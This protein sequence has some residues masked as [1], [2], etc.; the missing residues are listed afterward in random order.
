[1]YYKYIFPLEDVIVLRR[2]CHDSSNVSL[3]LIIAAEAFSSFYF[4]QNSK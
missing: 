3:I 2:G 4:E 1:M